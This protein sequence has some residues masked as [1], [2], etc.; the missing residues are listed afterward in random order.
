MLLGS[1]PIPFAAFR[2]TA[3][4][5]QLL[6]P[7]QAAFRPA[8]AFARVLLMMGLITALAA[9]GAVPKSILKEGQARLDADLIKVTVPVLRQ[10]IAALTALEKK[11]VVA[12]D[13]D[14]AIAARTERIKIETEVAAQEKLG[15]LLAARQGKEAV[16]APERIV[17]KPSE[18]KLE[19]VR[20]DSMAD[21]LTD[22]KGVGS[23]ATWKLSGLPPGGYEVVLRYSSGAL[24]GGT[25][26]VQ[27]NYFSLTSDLQTTLKGFTEANIGTLKIRDGDGIL[28]VSART[29]LKDNLMQ[30]KS[31]ELIPANR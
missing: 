10:Q 15:L 31:V 8:A 2:L 5:L 30:L 23:S 16:E 11:A 7:N 22:W 13:Y 24:E 26:M 4:S 14:T 18:A 27:E 1:P 6:T 17:F 29:V 9:P 28:K 12:R 21:V 20:Y 19:R 25:V 3:L